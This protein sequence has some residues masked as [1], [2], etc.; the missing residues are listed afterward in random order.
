MAITNE[1][2]FGLAVPLSLAD[3]PDS[4]EALTNISLDPRDLDIIDGLSS[5]GFDSQDLQTLS[6]LTTP[7]WRTFDRYITDVLTYNNQLSLSAG[8][9]I[10]TRGNLEVKGAVSSTAFRYALVETFLD[11][12]VLRWGDISTSRVSS[13]SSI[14]DAIVYGADVNIAAKLSV[15][16]L[17]TRSTPQER[18][19]AAEVPTHRVRLNINGAENYFLVMKGIP[20]RFKGF[21]RDVT[22]SVGFTGSPDPAWRIYNTDG[23]GEIQDFEF[24]ASNQTSTLNYGSPFSSEKF[25]EI[26]KNPVEIVS[27]SLNNSSIQELPKTK[28]ENLVSLVFQNNG[29]I[30]FP[31]FVFLAPQLQTL[32]IENN[33]FFNSPNTDER[34]FSDT[35]GKRIPDTVQ[36]LDIVGCFKGGFQPHVLRNL[37]SLST[38]DAFRSTFNLAEFYPDSNNPDGEL[39][40]FSGDLS[41]IL[42]HSIQTIR[43]QDND[44]RTIVPGRQGGI[45]LNPFDTSYPPRG[46]LVT[47]AS[48]GNLTNGEYSNVSLNTETGSGAGATADVIV[49]NGFVSFVQVKDPGA[50]YATNDTVSIDSADLGFPGG[51]DPVITIENVFN[52]LSVEQISSIVSLDL[53][54][55]ELLGDSDKKVFN[56]NCGANVVTVVTRNTR[57]PITDCSNFSLLQSYNNRFGSNRRS[58]HTAWNGY[59]GRGQ[60]VEVELV[61]PGSGYPLGGTGTIFPGQG[62]DGFGTGLSLDVAYFSG[63]IIS[64]TINDPGEDYSRD[65]TGTFVLPGGVIPATFN[66]KKVSY[67]KQDAENFKF[68]NCSSLTTHNNDYSDIRGYLPKYVGCTELTSYDFYSTD[69]IVAGRPGKR[70]ALSLFTSGG[71]LNPL[72]GFTIENQAGASSPGY[73]PGVYT[74]SDDQTLN[75]S[76]TAALVEVTVASTGFPESYTVLQGGEGYTIGDELRFAASEFEPANKNNLNK[77]LRIAVTNVSSGAVAP[78]NGNYEPGVYTLTDTGS[79][80]YAGDGAVVTVEVNGSGNVSNY[81]LSSGGSDY[82]DD[83]SIVVDVPLQGGFTGP[84]SL[85][86]EEAEPARIL[87]NDQF[88]GTPNISSV[89]IR[90]INPDFKGVIEPGAFTPLNASMTFLRLEADGQ[91]EGNFPNL[92]SNGVLQTVYSAGQGWSGPLPEFSLAAS[93]RTL[94]LNNNN[95]TGEIAYSSKPNLIELQLSNNNLT[96]IGSTLNL[97][98]V[99]FF[100]L[101][102]NSFG[103]DPETGEDD[104]TTGIL[105]DFTAAIQNVEFL[106]LNDN[107]FTSY[108]SGSAIGI[109]KIRSFDISNNKLGEPAIDQLLYDFVSNYNAAPRGGVLINLQGPNMSPPSQFPPIGGTLT[110][111]NDPPDPTINANG[112]ITDL[113]GVINLPAIDATYTPV[114]KKYSGVSTTSDGG[115]VGAQFTIDVVSEPSFTDVATAVNSVAT[116]PITPGVVQTIPGTFA[117]SDGSNGIALTPGSYTATHVP[118]PGESANGSGAQISFEIQADGIPEGAVTVATP[119]GTTGTQGYVAG[120]VYTTSGNGSGLT[121]RVLTIDVNEGIATAEIVNPGSG[122]G[123]P[124]G[125]ETVTLGPAETGGIANPDVNGSVTVNVLRNFDPINLALVNGGEGFTLQSNTDRI[126]IDMS[127]YNASATNNL[128]VDIGTVDEY[129]NGTTT[130]TTTGGTGT[131]AEIEVT[132]VDGGYNG[133]VT[134]TIV[135]QPDDGGY[136]VGDSLEVSLAGSGGPFTASFTVSDTQ[137]TWYQA[138]DISYTVT[139]INNVGEGYEPGD[140]I[141]TG[142]VIEFVDSDGLTVSESLEFTV[143]SVTTLLDKSVQRGQGA[144]E[145]LRTKGWTVQVSS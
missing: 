17:R 116:L 93:L 92:N 60:V 139:Q 48:D 14:G 119:G 65:L 33:P 126:V 128:L 50:G 74:V 73:T 47:N 72:G 3:I 109:T 111:V 20:L 138:G 124:S 85:Q 125:S 118:T 41:N 132:V 81:S 27:L 21:F 36:T 133:G 129:T 37:T 144:V 114:A 145:F 108:L 32:R 123:I 31:D 90:V 58:V 102:N 135:N 77:N 2:I 51:V 30:E 25:I 127:P 130:E 59:V 24:N 78:N 9:D 98:N 83:E 49:S 22:A 120:A 11:P 113:G 71:I 8:V 52:T 67:P 80:S 107:N 95:F 6:G 69:N 10:R 105:P 70:P 18:T 45:E 140:V 88:T 62:S 53:N 35:V 56:L 84:V 76:T 89:D 142:A 79:G 55:N 104:F 68:L 38:L 143:A 75:S 110:D 121:I 115:G 44:F 1:R 103:R 57:L 91:I 15:G 19:F 134:G 61:N 29:L 4:D 46:Y 7:I 94:R 54:D 23:T 97:P 106:Q 122:Y 87:Y 136:T 34:F 42:T 86:I 39:P 43:L 66:I 101:D 5:T 99:E 100:Y 131:G 63:Q 117:W 16:S 112:F 12:P 64:L 137:D 96:S 40:C 141:T 26:Y 82:I 13:W 28:L